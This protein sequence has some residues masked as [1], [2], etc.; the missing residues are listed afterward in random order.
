MRM[1]TLVEHSNSSVTLTN[2]RDKREREWR[3]AS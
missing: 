2:N 1:T 3:I